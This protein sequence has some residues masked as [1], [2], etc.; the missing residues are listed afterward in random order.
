MMEVSKYFSVLL[1][2][3]S[4]LTLAAHAAEP[5]P[6]PATIEGFQAPKPAEHPRLFFR[7]N[8]VPALRE[9]MQTP[10]G[11]RMVARLRELLGN[12]GERLPRFEKLI[13]L[14]LTMDRTRP[15]HFTIGHPAGYGM[16]FQLT[17][18]KKY[19]DMARTCLERMFDDTLY[20]VSLLEIKNHL[21]VQKQ[22]TEKGVQ[23]NLRELGYAGKS[24][25]ELA[26]I[27]L[28]FGQSDMDPRFNWT[29][30]GTAMRAGPLL[31]NVALA[32]DLCYDGWDPDFRERVAREIFEYDKPEVFYQKYTK[33]RKVSL[34]FAAEGTGYP[35]GSNHYGFALGGAGIALLAVRGDPGIDTARADELLARVEANLHTLLT[36]GFGDRAYFSEGFGPGHIAAN[37]TL[38]PFLSAARV[39][40]GK[41]FVSPDTPAGSAARWLTLK[42]VMGIISDEEGTPWYTHVGGAGGYTADKLG[43]RGYTDGGE[44]G[45]GFGA[46]PDDRHRAAL[47]WTWSQSLG[48]SEPDSFGVWHYPSKMVVTMAHWPMDL[49]PINPRE[50]LPRAVMDTLHGYCIFRNDWKDPDDCVF[51]FL[52][53]PEG[54]HG[55]VRSPRSGA[56]GIFGLGIRFQFGVGAGRPEVTAFEPQKDGSGVVSF[57]IDKQPHSVA[58]DYSGRAGAAAVI[59]VAPAWKNPKHP[60][61]ARTKWT[62]R[63]PGWAYKGREQIGDA[64]LSRIW[65]EELA[66][67]SAVMILSRGD[68]PMP[69]A[70]GNELRVGKQTYTWDGTRL[71]MGGYR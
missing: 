58:V 22:W 30:P 9:R 16:L 2:A 40:W 38:I 54:R 55:Y 7:K 46:L 6:W 48:K 53:N 27:K 43:H 29:R 4:F 44:L 5:G 23:R 69:Q 28:T 10:Q 26:R 68:P 37:P 59:V 42:W 14:N 32:Y 19:A 70:H 21:S 60:I 63:E 39:A 47:L 8:E 33:A 11:K 34:A 1:L 66:G 65:V 62:G 45:Q 17:G 49:E 24:D 71:R 67:G 31:M 15:G 61:D 3:L 64:R 36:E 20:A 18:E 25:E 52:L 13:P 35:P 56:L 41:D 12:G 50:V 51:C 57:T